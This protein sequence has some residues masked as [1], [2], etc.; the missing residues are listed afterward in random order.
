MLEIVQ[1]PVLNDNYI[2]VLHDNDS[3]KTAVVDP[4]V[5]ENVLVVLKE[6]SWNLD[7]ILNTHHHN[8]HVGGNETLVKET[9]CKVVGFARDASRIPHISITVEDGDTF[10]L[11]SSIAQI[12]YVPGHTLGHILYWFEDAKALFCGDTLFS[13]GCGRLFEGTPEQMYYSLQRI[14]QMPEDTRIF[15][16]HEYTQ[17]NGRFALTVEPN[18]IDLQEFMDNVYQLRKEGLSTIPSTLGNELRANPFLRPHSAEIRKTLNKEHAN[19]GEV[20]AEIRRRKDRF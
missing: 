15:C 13:L 2:Y 4:A 18:N 20:F 19:D 17:D 1:I 8:D 6:K 10:A 14:A 3:E 9:G 7:Y 11:G 5:A 12:M 16:A